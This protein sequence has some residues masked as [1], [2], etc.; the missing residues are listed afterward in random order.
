M[1]PS[2]IRDWVCSRARRIRESAF[3]S[4]SARLFLTRARPCSMAF[5][6]TAAASRA[7]TSISSIVGTMCSSSRS[8]SSTTSASSVAAA[9]HISSVMVFARTSNVPRKMPGNPS[10]L[11]TW[12]GKSD[13]PV[14]M[15][16]APASFASQGQISGTG[17]AITK[18]IASSAIEWTHSFWI[19]PGPGLEAAITTSEPFIA[20][21]IPPSRS[22]EF[23]IWAS[24]HF[25][26]NSSFFFAISSRCGQRIPFES[27]RIMFPGLAPAVLRTFAV[28][29]FEAEDPRA[30]RHDRDIVPLVRQPPDLLRVRLDLEARLRDPGRVPDRE[31]LEA[32]NRDLGDDLDLPLVERVIPRGQLLRQVRSTE[33]L[34]VRFLGGAGGPSTLR[35]R[36]D[37]AAGGHRNHQ[38]PRWDA[39]DFPVGL[40][41]SC[42]C[43]EPILASP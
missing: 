38:D 42:L 36:A 11:F 16:R 3:S 34:L 13:R 35:L 12:L 26:R 24:S 22:P 6:P 43:H 1:K 5:M 37:A 33:L 19:T 4:S 28:R 41:L 20:S 2:C 31:V 18:R 10:E 9:M 15:I 25:S 17:F 7:N 39:R 30:V 40:N 14:A 32:P 27:T 23:V 8:S 29:M 21:G